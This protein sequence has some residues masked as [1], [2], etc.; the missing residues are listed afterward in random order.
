MYGLLLLLLLGVMVVNGVLS[1][2]E[3]RLHRRFGQQ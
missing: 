3:R 1:V 2:W